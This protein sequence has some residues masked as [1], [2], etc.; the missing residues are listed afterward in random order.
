MECVS[1]VAMLKPP[2][3]KTNILKMDNNFKAAVA[4]YDYLLSYHKDG[5]SFESRNVEI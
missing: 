5:Y 3:T 1:K 2:I 4:L